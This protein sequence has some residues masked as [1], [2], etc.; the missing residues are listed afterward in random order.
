MSTATDAALQATA[1]SPGF[2][3][4]DLAR[5]I[6]FYEGLGF[7]VTERWEHEGTLLGVMVGAGGLNIGLSQDDW[8]KGR[9]RTKGVGMRL[10][11]ITKQD[12]TELASRARN[13]GIQLD[14]EPHET[15]W[16]SRVFEVTDP[17]GFKLTIAH[18]A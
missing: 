17:D 15:E 8:K 1:V 10:W 4:N 12:I 18:S 6:A 14:S 5:S 9:D 11:I 7:V 16:G 3:V 2:T 13:A